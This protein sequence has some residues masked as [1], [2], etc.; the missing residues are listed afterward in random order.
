MNLHKCYVQLSLADDSDSEIYTLLYH[1]PKNDTYTLPFYYG[2]FKYHRNL[3]QFYGFHIDGILQTGYLNPQ[4]L[5]GVFKFDNVTCVQPIM[6]HLRKKH[7]ECVSL[8]ALSKLI[9]AQ[10]LDMI[11]SSSLIRLD[12]NNAV[13]PMRF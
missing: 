10:K 9:I 6:K 12:S 7:L 13:R 11:Q 5:E 1:D 3:P 8:Q 2:N 4:N